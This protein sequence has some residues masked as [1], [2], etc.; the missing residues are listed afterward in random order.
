[1]ASLLNE[2]GDP[3][4]DIVHIDA[5][6]RDL[7][8]LGQLLHRDALPPAILYEQLFIGRVDRRGLAERFSGLG[9]R[10]ASGRSDCFVWKPASVAR[11]SVS[12]GA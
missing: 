10:T 3:P 11:Q 8:I 2:L 7:S 12:L 4:V 9:Y 5:E 1:M 6:G